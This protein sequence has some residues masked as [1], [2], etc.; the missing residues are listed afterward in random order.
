VPPVDLRDYL[1]VLRSRWMLITAITLIGV[2]AAAVATLATTPQY[3]STTTVLISAGDAQTG[4][5][6]AYTGSLLSQQRI[7]SYV[8]IA[9]SRAIARAVVKQLGLTLSPDVLVSKMSVD[10]PSGTVLL[11]LSVTD[12]NPSQAQRIAAAWVDQLTQEVNR[13]EEVGANGTSLFTVSVVEP[14]TLPTTPTYPRP[15]LNLALGLVVGLAVG[16]GTAVLLETLDT[17]VKTVTAL[18]EIAGAPLLG[19]LASDPE[20]QRH[21]VI[22]RDRQ[23]SPQS[24]AFRGIRTNLQF[25]DVDRRPRTILVTSALPRE[26]KTTVAVNLAVA[27]AEAGAAVALVEADLRRPS[28]ADR[29][30][31][32]GGSG[33]TDV[34]IGRAG[35]GE[36]IHQYGTGGRLWVLTSG[37]L[38]PNPSELLG[39]E[40]MRTT[41][42][43]LQRV[44][45]VIIDA[46][47]LLPV[48]D[49]AVLAALTDGAILVTAVSSTRREQ[50]RLAVERLEAVGGR[51]LGVVANRASTRGADAY[52]YAYGYGYAAKGR[53]HPDA[54]VGA[55]PPEP[56]RRDTERSEG[57]ASHPNESATPGQPNGNGDRAGR[58]RVNGDAPGGLH[59]KI[60]LTHKYGSAEA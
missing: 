51:L 49:A 37:A 28:V 26:G 50:V 7:T 5:G 13:I 32:E 15:K 27:L 11:D 47:P 4:V 36:V 29:M 22:V 31:L 40:Q 56:F 17:R 59:R 54:S 45:F 25:V 18:A 57:S 41:L 48:T 21:P 52:A 16:V 23:H 1:R 55:V 44:T 42:K 38:P 9:R 60:D 10:N 8:D 35:I 3:R 33:L 46:P 6:A 34:L 19:A 12:P 24:E 14:A 58:A 2:G 43:E 30:G 39:S 20:I 53:S